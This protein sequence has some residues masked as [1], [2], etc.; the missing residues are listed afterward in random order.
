MA[1]PPDYRLKVLDT[2]NDRH[3]VIGA[4]WANENGSISI[5]VDPGCALTYNPRL[6]ATLF[7]VNAKESTRGPA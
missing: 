5:V 3:G 6:V 7:P 4:A 2:G 1:R